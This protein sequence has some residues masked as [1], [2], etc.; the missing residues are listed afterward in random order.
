MNQYACSSCYSFPISALAEALIKLK[1]NKTIKLSEQ[2]LID[3]SKNDSKIN[4]CKEGNLTKGFEYAQ[5][6]GLVEEKILSLSIKN[7]IFL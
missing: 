2:E 3:C 4:G 6:I 1:Y 5:Q 7:W